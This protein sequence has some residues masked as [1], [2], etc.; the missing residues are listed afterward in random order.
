MHDCKAPTIFVYSET[1]IYNH[2][3]ALKEREVCIPCSFIVNFLY[4]ERDLKETQKVF[5]FFFREKL[6]L[7]QL[8]M[9]N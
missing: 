8:F 1:L 4:K 3:Q 5:F 9:S 2:P 6:L 7:L